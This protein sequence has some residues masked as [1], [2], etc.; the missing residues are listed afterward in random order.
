MA[1]SR[2]AAFA[3]FPV[4]AALV[5]AGIPF[6]HA[7]TLRVAAASSLTDAFTRIGAAFEAV[8]P[9]VQLEIGFAGSQILRAQIEQGAAVDVFASADLA[10]MEPL[11]AAD[12]V[13]SP[14]VFAHNALV[15]VTSTK[16]GAVRVLGDLGRSGVRLVTAGPS[17]PAGRYT[18]EV[19]RAMAAS[20]RFGM[21]FGARFEA[22]VRSRETSV[23]GVLMKVSLGEADAGFV[24]RTD[25]GA[26]PGVGILEIPSEWNVVTAYPIAVVKGGSAEDLAGA[27][28]ELV[29]H[30]EGQAILRQSGFA[31]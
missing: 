12:V 30:G 25:V 1:S 31:E 3:A 27:F 20:G 4:A 23:R 5:L 29:T 24:Y 17:V 21:D 6:A 22:N 9:G 11:V 14:V 8:H 15:V 28:V 10:Q 19:V 18:G 2:V 16:S 13:H 26:A 7:A